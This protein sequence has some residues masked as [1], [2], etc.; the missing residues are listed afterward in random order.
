MS[1][2]ADAFDDMLRQ[3][4]K[5]A[6]G[7]LDAESMTALAVHRQLLAEGL[8]NDSASTLLAVSGAIAEGMR[9]AEAT[10]ARAGPGTMPP[11]LRKE[12]LGKL[13]NFIAEEVRQRRKQEAE[14]AKL[15]GSLHP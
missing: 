9:S 2:I 13:A 6:A 10:H 1:A 4:T 8:I 11:A 14:D 5:E 12:A 7:E 15:I 3:Q